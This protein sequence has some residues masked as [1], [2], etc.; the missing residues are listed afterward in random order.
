[1]AIAVAMFITASSNDPK[2][3]APNAVDHV[4]PD[5]DQFVSLYRL[6]R[7]GA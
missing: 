2:R 1:M 3:R 5:E 4:R 7:H 6:T